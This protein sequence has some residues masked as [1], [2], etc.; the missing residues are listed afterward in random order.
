MTEFLL[1][2]VPL[3]P[4]KRPLIWKNFRPLRVLKSF[5]AFSG[6]PLFFSSDTALQTPLFLEKILDAGCPEIFL[7]VLGAIAVF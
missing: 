6:L 4:Y 7:G 5:R 3:Q 2:L 1:I